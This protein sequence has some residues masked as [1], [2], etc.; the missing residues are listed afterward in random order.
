[1]ALRLI[2]SQALDVCDLEIPDRPD[3]QPPRLL[4]HLIA[5]PLPALSEPHPGLTMCLHDFFRPSCP[6]LLIALGCPI[7]EPRCL[8]RYLVRR[9]FEI[10]EGV[11][12]QHLVLAWEPLQEI[13]FGLCDLIKLPFKILPQSLNITRGPLIERRNRSNRGNAEIDSAK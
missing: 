8:V 13:I 6:V 11:R 9:P 2:L 1:M 7:R 10:P 4:P 3:L 5:Q 12:L